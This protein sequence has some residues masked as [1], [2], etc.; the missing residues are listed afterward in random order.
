MPHA[1]FCIEEYKITN[2]CFDIVAH[3]RYAND[4][5]PSP[6]LT[7]SV[8]MVDEASSIVRISSSASEFQGA[9][10]DW[11]EGV[12]PV[13]FAR[14]STQTGGVSDARTPYDDQGRHHRERL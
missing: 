8:S 9:I 10:R 3:R 7:E 1:L 12:Y 2:N 11:I 4:S 14:L 6:T 5:K 13:T